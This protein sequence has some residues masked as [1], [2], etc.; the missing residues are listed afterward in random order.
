MLSAMAPMLRDDERITVLHRPDYR[1]VGIHAKVA[2][3]RIPIPMRPSWRRILAERLHLARVTRGI[4]ATVLDHAMLPAPRT[5]CALSLTVHDLR[6][7]DG[8]GIHTGWLGR[9]ALRRACRQAAVVIAPS[10]FTRQRITET[11]PIRQVEVIANGVDLPPP[12]TAKVAG[13]LLHVGHLEPRKNLALLPRALAVLPRDQRP[14]LLLVGAD[15]GSGA[16][17]RQLADR[18]G[19]ADS[20][21][22]L[23]I[24]PEDRLNQ[25]YGTARAI[26]VPSRY[27][28]FGLCALEGLAHGRPVLVADAGALVEVTAEHAV[29]LPSDDAAAWARAIEETAITS[30]DQCD[31]RIARAAQFSWMRAATDLLEVWRRLTP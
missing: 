11:A 8:F 24:V 15:A 16:A 5:R 1:P 3:Q 17:L 25:L 29:H 31:Q 14:T 23:G 26:V 2:W 19:V 7:V 10:H 27:E 6:S 30:D 13:H 22:F 9:L 18:L 28:G 21:R 4:G 20:V 12:R